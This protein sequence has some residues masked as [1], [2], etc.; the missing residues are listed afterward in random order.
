MTPDNEIHHLRKPIR[1]RGRRGYSARHFQ[2]VSP[3][4]EHTLCGVPPSRDDIQVSAIPYFK[5]WKI[6]EAC[7]AL[8]PGR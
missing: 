3:A 1:Y 6:C 2:A 5:G 4:P 8:I 7:L